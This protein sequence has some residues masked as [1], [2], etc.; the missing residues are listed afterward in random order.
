[1]FT[2]FIFAT[3]YWMISLVEQITRIRTFFVDRTLRNAPNITAY[4]LLFNALIFVNVSTLIGSTQT[5][6]TS[7]QFIFGD[8]V[9][10]WRAHSL[11]KHDYPKALPIP[12]F[13]LLLTTSTLAFSHFSSSD[14]QFQAVS[15]FGTIGIRI[16]TFF[17]R[18]GAGAPPSDHLI[19]ALDVAQV[20]IWVSSLLTNL[21]AT[22]IMTHKA[23]YA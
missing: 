8:A 11:C 1:M 20:G 16:A 5:S 10:V 12:I 19:H 9:V 18:A 21:S 22:L 7:P 15:V 17:T 6:T 4:A 2:P 13:L 14:K 23:W 3:S